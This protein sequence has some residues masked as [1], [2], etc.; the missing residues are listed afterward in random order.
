MATKT[1]SRVGWTS[2]SDSTAIPASS[3]APHDAG[4]VGGAVL[5]LDQHLAVLGGQQPADL[6]ADL[7]RRASI[8]P[9]ASAARCGAC[10]PRP[11]A[12]SGVPSATIRPLSMI[13]TR[14]ASWSASS[15]YWVVRKTVV[16]SSV[17]RSHLLPDRLAADRV[18][19]GGR[20]VE[21][22]HARLVDERRG[23]VE[24]A[25]HPAR[26]GADAAVGG[27]RPGRP[28]RAGRRRAACPRRS[29]S[30]AASPAGGSARGRS[31]AGRAPPPAGRRRSC[32]AP[33]AP[34]R[35]RRGRRRWR[36]RRSAAA[37]W[38]AS[39]PW[40]SCRRRWG[41]GSR[42]S[43]PRRPR[44]R[45]PAPRA[46]R[47]RRAPAPRRRSQASALILVAERDRLCDAGHAD[48]SRP[49]AG[50]DRAGGRRIGASG[51]GDRQNPGPQPSS[52]SG[53]GS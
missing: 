4:D 41:R 32:G 44:G 8:E 30:P 43:R 52:T 17:E 34:R 39:A 23:E 50:G 16:P 2:S 38:S 37:A 9:S 53:V 20:L 5:D 49:G 36:C 18:E 40:S 45:R 42:R 48:G 26:V 47:R 11:S 22:E 27:V 15:R 28:A 31:S 25:L 33:P 3:S 10:R 21:E 46:P 6:A 35:R 1:S 14:S 51:A 12:T 19:A 13:P 24:P 7:L 29:G